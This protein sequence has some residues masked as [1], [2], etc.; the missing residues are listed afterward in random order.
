MYGRVFN[1]NNADNATFSKETPD[2][3]CAT[4]YS[5]YQTRPYGHYSARYNGQDIEADVDYRTY[6]FRKPK[7]AGGILGGLEPYPCSNGYIYV[8]N[9]DEDYL[10]KDNIYK[11]WFTSRSYSVSS[12]G[13]APKSFEQSGSSVVEGDDRFNS[14]YRSVN[15]AVPWIVCRKKK[16]GE[17]VGEGFKKNKIY[18][19]RVSPSGDSTV[20]YLDTIGTKIYHV[21]G[22]IYREVTQNEFTEKV[23]DVEEGKRFAFLKDHVETCPKTGKLILPLTVDETLSSVFYRKQPELLKELVK[24]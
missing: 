5:K 20:Y 8:D 14:N 24:A 3:L 10:V 16:C 6:V 15:S 17:G 23:F 18:N 7:E 13:I 19:V 1:L 11:T 21:D 22:N 4:N 12:A 9:R 2:S